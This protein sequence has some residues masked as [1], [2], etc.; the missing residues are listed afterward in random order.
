MLN[1]LACCAA[2][3][4]SRWREKQ[5]A[6]GL[7][8]V[9][10]IL[11]RRF[12]RTGVMKTGALVVDDYAHHPSEM[13]ATLQ[14]VRQT[15]SPDFLRFSTAYLYPNQSPVFRVY[16][17]RCNCV[18]SACANLIVCGAGAEH[19]WNLCFRFESKI[20]DAVSFEFEEI[21]AYLER[22]NA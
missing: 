18:I 6:A 11:S 21:C 15:A 4:F 13:R 5:A 3:W 19:H 14:T 7:K 8:T 12:E 22:E 20:P 9:S 16:R 17:G 10:G 2:A 1:A